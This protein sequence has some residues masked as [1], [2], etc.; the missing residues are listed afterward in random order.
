MGSETPSM[1]INNTET[2]PRV[3]E[4]VILETDGGDRDYV[5]AQINHLPTENHHEVNVG[6]QEFD[7]EEEDSE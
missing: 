5:V 7:Y 4:T 1:V 6:L 3:G 2:Y